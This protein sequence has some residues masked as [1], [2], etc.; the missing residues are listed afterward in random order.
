MGP[1]RRLPRPNGALEKCAPR[2]RAD[3]DEEIEG[4]ADGVPVNDTLFPHFFRLI[5]VWQ[6]FGARFGGKSIWNG[7]QVKV[8]A[9]RMGQE[10]IVYLH[11]DEGSVKLRNVNEKKFLMVSSYLFQKGL[12][13]NRYL[14]KNP[15]A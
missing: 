12:I 10:A 14:K 13:E 9:G 3:R 4:I 11:G 15:T 2:L 5:L 6:Y 7:R 1:G 8:S